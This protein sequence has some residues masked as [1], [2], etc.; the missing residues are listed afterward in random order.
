MHNHYDSKI[1]TLYTSAEHTIL[2]AHIVVT[3]PH[4]FMET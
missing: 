3:K 1:N 4:S 2:V